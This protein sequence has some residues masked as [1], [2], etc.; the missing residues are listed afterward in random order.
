MP[1]AALLALLPSLISGGEE[2]F[3]LI[4]SITSTLKTTTEMTPEQQ[5]TFD[6]HIADLESKDWWQVQD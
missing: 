4:Q 2:I 6:A 5:A 3:A 1:I